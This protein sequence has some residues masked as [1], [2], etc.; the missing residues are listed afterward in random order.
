MNYGLYL[1]ASGVLTNLYRQDVFANN[2]AN[3]ETTG[4]KPDVPSISQRSPENIEDFHSFDVSNRLLE[5]LGGGV[6]AGPQR[7]DFSSGAIE[8]TG[9]P[10]DVALTQSD[11]FFVVGQADPNTGEM[12]IKLTRDGRIMPDAQGRL[13]L[14]S[15]LPVLDESDRPIV[16]DRNIP[17]SIDGQ[18]Q[19]LQNGQVVGQLQVA[20]VQALDQLVKADKGLLDMPTG[21]V[22]EIDPA[23]MLVS[24]AIE[25]SG[26]DPFSTLMDV[27]S[28][29]KAAGSNANMIKYHD[30]VM[31]KAINSLGRVS[32]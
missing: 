5:R 10:L 7:I 15:G 12:S 13:V 19:V 8:T 2:L 4:F 25:S 23:P 3:L 16:V 29:A 26:V 14:P 21:D 18:G 30:L 20:R 31:D 9:N 6:L 32:G 11:R 22:R 24:G 1:S 28:A 27:T 17:A